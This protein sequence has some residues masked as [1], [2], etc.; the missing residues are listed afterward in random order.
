[1]RVG[2]VAVDALD[3]GQVLLRHVDQLG[4]LYL[5]GK[6]SGAVLQRGAVFILVTIFLKGKRQSVSTTARP[7]LP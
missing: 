5:V 6:V 4:G 3:L 1:M 2:H 7:P